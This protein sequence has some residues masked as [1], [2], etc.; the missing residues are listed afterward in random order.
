M[1]PE[2]RLECLL[3]EMAKEAGYVLIHDGQ[4]ER[5]NAQFETQPRF[6]TRQYR[7]VRGN[8]FVDEWEIFRYDRRSGYCI[9]VRI[10]KREPGG[11]KIEQRILTT[12]EEHAIVEQ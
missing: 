5:G 11:T 8:R 3:E 1:S 4:F 9:D 6:F 2:E 7:K 12:Q 10:T